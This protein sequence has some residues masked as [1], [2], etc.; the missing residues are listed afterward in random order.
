MEAAG[1]LTGDD[2]AAAVAKVAADQ[3]KAD[4]DAPIEGRLAKFTGDAAG[5]IGDSG[6]L[7]DKVG[8]TVTSVGKVVGDIGEAAAKIRSKDD[9]EKS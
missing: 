8:Q 6:F 2:T 9:K 5:G 4:D 3:I 1:E 7:G